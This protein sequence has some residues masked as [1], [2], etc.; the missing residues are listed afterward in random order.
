MFAG[1]V[2]EWNGNT[3][4]VFGWIFFAAGCSRL[5]GMFFLT[6]MTL[7]A[8]RQGEAFTGDCLS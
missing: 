3:L 4:K 6:R 5:I 2:A 8:D 7:P 1:Q